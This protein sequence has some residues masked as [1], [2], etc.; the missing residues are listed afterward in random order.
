LIDTGISHDDIVLKSVETT[1]K[2]KIFVSV[3]TLRYLVRSGRVSP[4]K[5]FIARLLKVKPVISVLENGKTVL[6]DRAFTY[7]ANRRKVVSNIVRSIGNGDIYGYSVN[8][9]SSPVEA[10]YF[11]DQ[12]KE[13]TGKEPDFVSSVSPALGVH[14]GKGTV[15]VTF[16]T[17]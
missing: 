2:S 9:V 5:G 7:K 14:T 15:A 11:I 1:L 12:M 6:L 16:I 4:V 17:N 8:H 13:I 3:R 10:A